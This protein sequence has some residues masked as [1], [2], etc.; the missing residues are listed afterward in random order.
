M[1]KLY[2]ISKGEMPPANKYV[3]IYLGCKPWSDSDDE[4]GKN[5]RVAKCV[6]GITEEQRLAYKDSENFFIRERCK[7][8]RK[9]DV[10]GNNLVPYEFDEFGPSCHFGQEVDIWTY[11]PKI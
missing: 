11:L 9:G 2:Y 3:L 10:C 6:Y 1:Q 5:W 4:Y 8:Y 7:Y